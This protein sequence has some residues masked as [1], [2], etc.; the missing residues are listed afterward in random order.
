[1]VAINTNSA[2][3]AAVN[4]LNI[5]AAQ[6][7][8]AL[9]QLASGSKI[10]QA[11]DDAAGLAIM[12]RIRSDTV[13]LQQASTNAAQASA[14]LQTAD[15]AASNISD[16]LA[17]MKSLASEA[18][19]GTSVGQSDSFINAEFTQLVSQIDSISSGARY[20]G[21]S[22]VGAG[23]TFSAG[24][25]VLVG[26]SST[27]VISLKLTPLDATTLKLSSATVSGLDVANTTDATA[28]L[29][30]LD[31]AIDTVSS[32]RANIGALES[33]F[34]F[35]ASSINSQIQNLQAASSAI[36]DTD[37]AATQSALSSAE[38]KTQAAVAAEVAADQ[39]PN[40]LLK[41]LG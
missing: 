9:S 2:A 8:K 16:I 28:M 7:T 25:S 5:N 6:E 29:A 23:S 3:N 10:V 35:S 34:N 31:T 12:T 41:L 33:R 36:G 24:V 22:L 40:T 19:S 21:Q 20:D 17:R 26:S 4:F 37:V 11:S 32:A 18:A 14:I 39:I 38:V 30:V 1:M 15:S 27:D 13:T